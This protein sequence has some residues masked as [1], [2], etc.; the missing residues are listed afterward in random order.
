M[1]IVQQVQ[2]AIFLVAL[3]SKHMILGLMRALSGGT[4]LVGGSAWHL[5]EELH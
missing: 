1:H 2:V 5:L 4:I 3:H